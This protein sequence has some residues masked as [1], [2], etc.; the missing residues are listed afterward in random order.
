MEQTNPEGSN[1]S[2]ESDPGQGQQQAQGQGNQQ[3]PQ[4][5]ESGRQSPQESYPVSVGDWIVTM[6]I[7]AIPLVNIV[8]L[9]VWGFSDNTKLSKANWAKATLIFM[10]IMLVL[11]LIIFVIIGTAVGLSGGF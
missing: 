8:M 7:M 4:A 11:Y 6:I 9:F 2:Q 5:Q 1:P 10:A 3:P